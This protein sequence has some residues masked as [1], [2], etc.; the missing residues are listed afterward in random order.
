MTRTLLVD[1]DSFLGPVLQR[2]L[3][4]YGISVSWVE[5]GPEPLSEERYADHL[6]DHLTK[7]LPDV[8][9]LDVMF[10]VTGCPN[11]E[12]PIGVNLLR[13]LKADSRYK[14]I[15]II[16]YTGHE[17]AAASLAQ[18]DIM[19]TDFSVSK[20]AD[21]YAWHFAY[22]ADV[23]KA[24]SLEKENEFGLKFIVGNSPAMR[25][26]AA[27]ISLLAKRPVTVLI[28]GET[29]TGK[30]SIARALHYNGPR[31]NGP[32]FALNCAG[33]SD[34][35]QDSQLFGYVRGAYTGAERDELGAFTY[36]SGYELEAPVKAPRYLCQ[37]GP[38]GERVLSEAPGRRLIIGPRNGRPCGTLFLDEVAELGPQAQ[39]KLLRVLQSVVPLDLRSQNSLRMVRP[40][41]ALFELPV[42]VRI[43]A[44]TNVDLREAVRAGKFREDLFYRLSVV[45]LQVP[46][47]RE[48]KED[49]PRLY[50]HLINEI[51]HEWGVHISAS[52]DSKVLQDLATY[53]WPGNIRELRNCIERA[54]AK[55]PD[56][57]AR[58]DRRLVSPDPAMELADRDAKAA[59]QRVL[60]GEY[61]WSRLSKDFTDVERR[62]R[63]LLKVI[64]DLGEMRSAERIA[65]L[66]KLTG[67]DPANHVRQILTTL[68]LRLTE[69]F[70]IPEIS[71]VARTVLSD[72]SLGWQFVVESYPESGGKISKDR[73]SVLALIIEACRE[74]SIDP[75][76]CLD[77][78]KAE[79]EQLVVRHQIV[80][81]FGSSK[82]NGV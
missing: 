19:L 62:R 15:P 21:D 80:Q 4:G 38:P 57:E 18:E 75:A 28:K 35:L 68:R 63:A 49:I 9:V 82:T 26:I 59:A 36:A 7:D 69:P 53:D 32:F 25:A 55:L 73:S 5:F 2:E 71:E 42:D 70:E 31:A 78:S 66:L 64:I 60:A 13:R 81:P 29:G 3:G 6:F 10:R 48:R 72:G 40:I 41:G 23:I 61:S 44:G 54:A 47:L 14:N 33:L 43:I 37:V 65:K 76:E 17:D 46:P 45:E 39:A 12:E 30:E 50:A 74:A 16:L 22:L 11:P 79:L 56:G 67:K 51:S 20:P 58:I 52:T 24:A 1:D 27:E 77:I 8:L 34:A